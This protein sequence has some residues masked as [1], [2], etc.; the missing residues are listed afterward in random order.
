MSRH[1]GLARSVAGAS[2]LSS[3]TGELKHHDRTLLG[4]HHQVPGQCYRVY[5]PSARCMSTALQRTCRTPKAS[6]IIVY[7]CRPPATR[8]WCVTLHST[9]PTAGQAARPAR[10]MSANGVT[11]WHD[12]SCCGAALFKHLHFVAGMAG[13]RMQV[14]PVVHA[15]RPALP[16]SACKGRLRS[17]RSMK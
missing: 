1:T 2:G 11:D 12:L 10:Q 8:T 16:L 6:A 15:V 4:L 9:M 3:R 13:A 7:P 14:A 5:V 17:M